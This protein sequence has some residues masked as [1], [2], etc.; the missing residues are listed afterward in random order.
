MEP[1]RLWF[2]FLKLA[3]TD[4]CVNVDKDF[5]RDWGDIEGQDFDSWWAGATWRELFAIEGEVRLIGDDETITSNAPQSSLAV[6]LPLGKPIKETLADVE[7]LLQ[8]HSA[9]ANLSTI[10]KGRF[11]LS[12]GVEQGFLKHMNKARS[13]LRLYGYWLAHQGKD[14]KTRLAAIDYHDWAVGRL[15]NIEKWGWE[16]EKRKPHLPRSIENFV[17]YIR[18]PGN[19]KWLEMHTHKGK[20]TFPNYPEYARL[21]VARYIRKARKLASNVGRGE[22]PGKY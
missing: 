10:P 21:S 7:A 1:Y 22:F 12:A 15:A 5:Y 19:P 18:D 16:D 13:M 9:G 14:D 17:G 4:P 8:E 2:E 6:K 20:D 11:S 3:F